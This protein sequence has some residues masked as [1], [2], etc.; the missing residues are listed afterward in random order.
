MSAAFGLGMFGYS[1]ICLLVGSLIVF[2]IIN[3]L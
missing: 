2:Y 3:K 1:M